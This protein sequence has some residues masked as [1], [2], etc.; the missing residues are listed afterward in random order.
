MQAHNKHR[1]VNGTSRH[2]YGWKPGLPGQSLFK[3]ARVPA[4][5][6]QLPK[7]GML[8]KWV[9]IRDQGEYGSCTA[10]AIHEADGYHYLMGGKPDPVL[11]RFYTYSKV[12]EYEG[13][14]LT[15]DSGAVV[16][17]VVLSMQ[18]DG[19]CLESLWPY[20]KTH[21]SMAPTTACDAQ[22]VTRRELLAY[23]CPTMRTIKASI[24]LGSPVVF[25]FSCPVSI[26][27]AKTAETGLILPPDSRGF[28]GGHCVPIVG[29]DDNLNFG[30]AI[31]GGFYFAQS[32]GDWGMP[33]LGKT[34]GFG[35]IPYTYFINGWAMDA[36]AIVL[37]EI[38]A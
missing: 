33:L 19:A 31:F 11:S 29:Y 35:A 7:T 24:V 26:Q 5:D 25:G 21:F 17:D 28:D 15:E 9:T 8:T 16:A 4:A 20:D 14:P 13:T 3:S 37:N 34:S 36:H 23:A 1:D 22:A 2:L 6:I 27:D 12:R 10:N 38:P 30:S 18:K 32:W